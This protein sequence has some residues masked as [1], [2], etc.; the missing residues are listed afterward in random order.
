VKLRRRKSFAQADKK[1]RSKAAA[2][3]LVTP[4]ADSGSVVRFCTDEQILSRHYSGR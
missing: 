2:A 1:P 3:D 4:G